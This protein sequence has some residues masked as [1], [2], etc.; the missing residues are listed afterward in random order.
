MKKVWLIALLLYCSMGAAQ[1]SYRGSNYTFWNNLSIGTGADNICDPNVMCQF[2][3]SG[4]SAA[5]VLPRVTNLTDIVTPQ[6]GMFAYQ[7]SDNTVN[8]YN[9]SAWVTLGTGSSTP[10]LQTVSDVGATTTHVL[11]INGLSVGTGGGVGNILLGDANTLANMNPSFGVF[12]LGIGGSAL[13]SITT[14]TQNIALG[15]GAGSALPATSSRNTM[16]G[17]WD[18]SGVTTTDNICLSTGSGTVGMRLDLSLNNHSIGNNAL[19][20]VT[21]GQ[22][23]NGFGSGALMQLTSGTNNV[24]VGVNSLIHVTSQGY[25]TALGYAAG[26]NVAS[27]YNTALG[28]NALNSV[29]VGSQ[30]TG[31]GY[32]AG[33][34]L[35][36]GTSYNVVLGGYTGSG[37]TTSNNVFL[38]DGQG[39]LTFSTAWNSSKLK[40]YAGSTT[41]CMTLDNFSDNISVG[42]SPQPS[43]GGTN[44]VSIGTNDM[45]G[46]TTGNNNIAIGPS[47]GVNI[48]SGTDN[49]ML[50]F[51]AG[52]SL[53]ASAQNI[54]IGANS[55]LAGNDNT[56]VGIDAGLS[57]T[58]GSNIILGYYTAT[59]ISGNFNT[60]LGAGS[61]SNVTG[62]HNTVVGSTTMGASTV[63]NV[64]LI[65]ARYVG[66]V[67]DNSVVVTDGAGNVVINLVGGGAKIT[68]GVGSPETYITAPVGS[69]YLRSDGGAGTTLYVK[70]SGSGNTGWV[71]K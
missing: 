26:Y 50:G 55:G 23:N 60:Y 36:S 12:N 15:F 27:N 4:T 42:L 37:V 34:S 10:D 67:G 30:N 71:G 3:N 70:E 58:G 62:S 16:I 28:C 35:G 17:G 38:S 46:I 29:T 1:Q 9:G 57:S 19:A 39:N 56:V 31:V 25:N 59:N 44:N 51:Q 66:T 68:G 54:C 41:P 7:T 5:I 64:T 69:M 21:S 2:G 40:L 61:A 6:A 11:T 65:G 8:Y 49:I 18:G 45:P 14:G 20:N 47:A 33:F 52:A 22:Y 63:S 32:N 24:G 13:N 43:M 53:G 48:T